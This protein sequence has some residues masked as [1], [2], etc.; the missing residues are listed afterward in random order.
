MESDW[1]LAEAED[2]RVASGFNP[3]CNGN[4]AFARQQFNRAHLAQIHAH[5][6]IGTFAGSGFLD[7][8]GQR[9]RV[10]FRDIVD[11]FDFFLFLLV[12]AIFA[13]FV[14]LDD[15]HAHVID[16]GHDVFDLFGRHLILRQGS[17]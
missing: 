14:I 4:F 15:L 11:G 6:V 5:W 9:A 10:V 8:A 2:H 7:R 3:L 12:L 13:G 16:G 17:I 1:A